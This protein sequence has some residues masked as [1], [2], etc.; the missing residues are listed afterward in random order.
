M[1]PHCVAIVCCFLLGRLLRCHRR[2]S[3]CSSFFISFSGFLDEL[4]VRL[5]LCV[6]LEVL[7]RDGLVYRVALVV[8]S[9]N[10]RGRERR[11]PEERGSRG[12]RSG[13]RRFFEGDVR[14]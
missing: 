1:C 5:A 7:R 8:V 2:R 6:S 4:P 10:L 13:G 14:G 11:R 9:A 3:I 12:M